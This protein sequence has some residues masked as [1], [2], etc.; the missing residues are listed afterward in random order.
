[1]ARRVLVCGGRNYSNHRRFFQTLDDIAW[2]L[3]DLNDNELG[4]GDKW[5]PDWLIISGAATGA[6]S[7]AIEYAV[8]NWC[9]LEEYPADWDKY[10]KRAGYIR[11]KQMLEEGKPDLVIAFPGGKGTANMIKLAK[12]AGVEVIEVD[13]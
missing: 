3:G 1:L 5:L 12:E 4:E 7:L 13:F 6:D 2:A 10:G 8:V 9:Q 11:N